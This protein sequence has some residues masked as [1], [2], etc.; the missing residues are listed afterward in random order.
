VE[1]PTAPSP[2]AAAHDFTFADVPRLCSGLRSGDEAAF[3]FVHEQWNQRIVRYCLAL[4]AGN[5]ALAMDC[6]QATWL[7]IYRQVRPLPDE[8]ALWHWIACAARSAASDLHRVGGRYRRALQRFTEWLHFG[9]A[10]ATKCSGESQLL[11]A[12]DL[13]LDALDADERLLLDCR[14]FRRLPLEEI[15]RRTGTT[16]RA[17]EGRL[18]RL[19]D[20]LRH[21]IATALRNENL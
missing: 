15:A 9:S 4:A 11:A 8:S 17:I 18:A 2:P 1:S 3:R 21:T 12:L 13:A 6:V 10:R 16:T 7:R 19:R 14:Y 20:R 5:E